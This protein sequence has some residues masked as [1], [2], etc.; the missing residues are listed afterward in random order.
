MFWTDFALP[1]GTENFTSSR[2][3]ASPIRRGPLSCVWIETGN[4]SRPLACV[5]ID[6]EM[7]IAGNDASRDG[8]TEPAPVC[9]ICS[10]PECRLARV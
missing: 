1:A 7:R 2:S 4:S 3:P 8:E 10:H 9:R 6:H 5:W